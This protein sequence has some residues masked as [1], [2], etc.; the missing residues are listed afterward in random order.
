MRNDILKCL[1]N[2]PKKTNLDIEQ[3]NNIEY[4]NYNEILIEYNVEIGERVRSYLLV[5]KN[6]GIKPAIVAIHQHASNWSIGK[7][8]VVGKTNNDMFSYG[9]DLVKRGYVVIAPDLLCFE[10]RQGSEKFKKDKEMQKLYE[11]FE[12]CKYI[13]NGSCLQTKYLHD[14]SVAI[15]VVFSLEYVDKNNIG[16]IVHSLGGQEAIWLSWYDERIKCCVSSCGITCMKDLF[17]Y[18]VLHNFAFYI[19][20]LNNI[21]DIDEII[22]EISPRA[23][24]ITNG[25]KDE[26]H[27]PLSG[28]ERIEKRNKNNSSF[29][30]VRFDDEHK[31][32]DSEK[33]IAYNF[34]DRYLK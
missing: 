9:L 1:G 29:K 31:F 8:E 28:V 32:N 15:D 21:C 18:E 23:V 25:L 3:I 22:N 6:E 33:N 17:D 24:L 10:S 4:E 5:P 16:T 19:P 2:F 30:S 20:N 7:S 11:R 12:F 26:R 34:L 13:I 14:L 27:C